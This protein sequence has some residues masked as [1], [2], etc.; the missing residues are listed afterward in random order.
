MNRRK[1]GDP[2]G[3]SLASTSG[4]ASAVCVTWQHIGGLAPETGSRRNCSRKHCGKTRRLLG[5]SIGLGVSS[6]L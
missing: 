4:V 1:G 3:H 5:P 2:S 6:A